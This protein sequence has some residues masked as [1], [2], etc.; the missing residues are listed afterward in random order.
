MITLDLVTSSR[1]FDFHL[2][3]LF[4]PI[5]FSQEM[6]ALPGASHEIFF[7]LC[8]YLSAS[9]QMDTDCL[10]THKTMIK[11]STRTWI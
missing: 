2:E 7:V 8:S 1:N 11:N 4:D 5:Q 9:A 6:E 10:F 3:W